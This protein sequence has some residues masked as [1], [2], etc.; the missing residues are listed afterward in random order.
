MDGTKAQ[1]FEH[2]EI[3]HFRLTKIRAHRVFLWDLLRE[4]SRS[5]LLYEEELFFHIA[6]WISIFLLQNLFVRCLICAERRT[7]WSSST[8]RVWGSFKGR[9]LLIGLLYET[10]PAFRYRARQIAAWTGSLPTFSQSYIYVYG[11]LKCPRT[12]CILTSLHKV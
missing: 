8:R 5:A 10:H 9:F 12:R 3:F 2:S 4:A 11:I 6:P 1:K 7:E